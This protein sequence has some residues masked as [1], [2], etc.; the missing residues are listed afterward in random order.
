MELK[1]QV[2]EV[3]RDRAKNG[4]VKGDVIGN[5]LEIAGLDPKNN[6]EHQAL[7]WG[8]FGAQYG[9]RVFKDLMQG[10]FAKK[11]FNVKGD[12]INTTN[13]NSFPKPSGLPNGG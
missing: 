12:N 13:N 6:P 3:V 11:G 7:L 8:L 1:R 4:T 9:A 2:D 10:F 5:I